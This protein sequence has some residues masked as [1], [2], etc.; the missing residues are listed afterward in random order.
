MI[1]A[2]IDFM[3]RRCRTQEGPAAVRRMVDGAHTIAPTGGVI[4]ACGSPPSHRFAGGRANIIAN[5]RPQV[6]E[7]SR[8][9]QARGRFRNETP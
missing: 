4:H 1:N 6:G 9:T 5:A 3:A 2:S 7:S 8:L